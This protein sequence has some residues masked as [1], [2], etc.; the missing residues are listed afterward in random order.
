MRTARLVA[1]SLRTLQRHKLRSA[2]VM[3]GTLIGVAALNL[4]V[5]VG[6][7]VEKKLL[8]TVRMYFSAHSILVSSGGNLLAGGPRGDSARMT[9][10]DMEA[11]AAALPEI[12][13]WDPMQILNP[14]QARY[15]DAAATVRVVGAS[16]RAERV[17]QR[18]VTRGEFLDSAAVARSARVA[19]IGET[20]ARELFAGE[21]PLGSE[22]LIGGVSLRVQGVLE[23]MGTDAHGIDRDNEIVVPIST[24]MRRLMNLDVILGA[25]LLV[26]DPAQVDGAVHEITRV[27]RERHA[28]APGQP[29]DF[30]VVTPADVQR[31]VAKVQ[32]VLFL[33]LPLV[34]G[35]ALL[36]GGVVAASLTLLSVSERVSEIGLRRAM[37]A[38]ARDVGLQFLWETALTTLTG[39]LAG[40]AAGALGAL[41]I[42]QKLALQA[43]VS[44][45]AALL[46]LVLSAATG[47]AA[48]V[49][50]AR[51]AAMLQP[52]DALR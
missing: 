35:V 29:N 48:G 49:L 34:A 51:R 2:F 15:R 50:P 16:E 31:M 46:G 40:T 27:L 4:V 25:K 11:I 26:K 21:D 24:L 32:R 43:S 12:E 5:S 9:L 7:G 14:A 45:T 42:V 38:R 52:A 6:S 3:M 47:L 37:G 18:G 1:E 20:A 17:W 19:L 41:F 39:G 22:I 36:V 23:P 28:L 44:W 10:E 33:F 13:T 8:E 30:S